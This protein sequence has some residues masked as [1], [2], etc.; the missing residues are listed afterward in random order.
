VLPPT[1]AQRQA[2]EE[3]GHATEHDLREMLG[4]EE[5]LDGLSGPAWRERSSFGPTANIAGIRTGYGGPGVK[6]VLPAEAGALLDFRLVPD[7]RPEDALA[8]LEAHLEREGFDDVQVTVL[9]MAEPAGTPIEHPFV[10]RVAQIA[11]D[12]SGQPPSITPRIPGT[13]P[14]VASLQRHLG[15]PGVAAPD[16]PFYFGARAHAPNEHVRL[17]DL[18]HAIRFTHALF[19]SLGEGL[20]S[21]L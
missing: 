12:V 8:L 11:E 9:G 21:G 19:E 16:N 15:A 4:V 3:Q 10:Q 17:E 1:E 6:T 18:G 2:I 20:P 13:L 5:F 14:I 7:Q